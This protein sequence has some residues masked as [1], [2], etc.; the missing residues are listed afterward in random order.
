MTTWIR[1]IVSECPHGDFTRILQGSMVVGTHHSR[2]HSRPTAQLHSHTTIL[3]SSFF[4]PFVFRV[5]GPPPTFPKLVNFLRLCGKNGSLIARSAR[6][7]A[8][9]VG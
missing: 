2:S 1:D 3:F 4:S 9:R 8:D 5:G 7:G 6:P